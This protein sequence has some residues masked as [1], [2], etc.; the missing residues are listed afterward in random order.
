[1]L[2]GRA[3]RLSQHYG[4][5]AMLDVYYIPQDSNILVLAG[6]TVPK[7]GVQDLTWQEIYNYN[8]GDI[9]HYYLSAFGNQSTIYKVLSKIV[10]GNDSVTYVMEH[11]SKY[12]GPTYFTTHDTVVLTY[13]LTLNPDYNWLPRLP[14]EFIRQN[15]YAD[16]YS[17][18]INASQNR[19][20]K[21]VSSGY[22][23]SNDSCWMKLGNWGY[24]VIVVEENYSDG[25]GKTKFYYY[26]NE[27]GQVQQADEDLVY[28][29]K[30]SETWGTP[31]ASD[32]FQLV[33]VEPASVTN[34]FIVR[35]SP[36]P[37][38][39]HTEIQLQN[40]AEK[41]SYYFCIRDIFGRVIIQRNFD[42]NPCILTRDGIPD[43]MY[44]LSVY[45]RSGIIVGQ[46]KI[47]FE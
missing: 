41:E 47:L 5:A 40:G 22:V 16:L 17:Y 24:N 8:V 4:L 32:C 46:S 27:N 1:M 35:V 20:V 25:L 19:R 38:K 29:K 39:T 33:G 13:P 15:Q 37:V 10:N 30:G 9:F 28:Y 11:C 36:N 3:I 45:N 31:L 42:S 26:E 18:S 23:C 34:A 6:K 7:M 2:N 12:L 14:R 44:F 43:G 21:S